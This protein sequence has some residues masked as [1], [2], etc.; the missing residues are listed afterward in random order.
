[1]RFIGFSQSRKSSSG[2][3]SCC[4]TRAPMSAPAPCGSGSNKTA[5]GSNRRLIL[6]IT[7]PPS[8]SCK[9]VC[10]VFAITPTSHLKCMILSAKFM[11]LH[12]KFMIL[13]AKLTLR[14]QGLPPR[15][16][17]AA[18][19]SRARATIQHNN[20]AR[21]SLKSSKIQ[22]RKR[23]SFS[24]KSIRKCRDYRTHLCR[25]RAADTNHQHLSAEESLHFQQKNLHFSAAESSL[26]AEES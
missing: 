1:M 8:S 25:A 9:N 13:H 15:S 10:R 19:I 23:A 11:I 14:S 2:S 17:A 20:G 4:P 6:D 26:S 22:P 7:A 24:P 16:A 12:A 5:A 3:V 21:Y 18:P